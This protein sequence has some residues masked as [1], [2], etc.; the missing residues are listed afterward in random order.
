MHPSLA[1]TPRAPAELV[2]GVLFVA[3]A[4]WLGVRSRADGRWLGALLGAYLFAALALVTLGHATI[5]REPLVV[6]SYAVLLVGGALAAWVLVTRNLRELGASDV[7]IGLVLVGC[8]VFGIFGA[9]VA[10]VASG[11]SSGHAGHDLRLAGLGV[12]GA[13]A[14]DLV[15]LVA[16]FRFLPARPTLA[17]VLDAGAPGIA[18]NLA[19]ARLGCLLAGCCFGA[20]A[21]PGS[22]F[23]LPAASFD[24]SSPAGAHYASTAGVHVWAAQPIEAAAALAIAIASQICWARRRHARRPGAIIAAAGLAY[25]VVRFA[26]ERLRAD[27]PRPV[28]GVLT[29]WQ[30]LSLALVV[31]CLPLVL[32]RRPVRT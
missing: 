17:E 20:P 23:A 30:V 28:L 31:A 32:R 14:A 8:F 12:F 9:R 1:L 25:G 13:F 16:L 15:F 5:G 2:A 4:A 27:S 11:E 21:D 24:S 19:V 26:L 7:A 3:L 10:S 29:V 18:L 6:S 22:L